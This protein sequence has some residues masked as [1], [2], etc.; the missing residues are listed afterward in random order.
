MD[1]RLE[2]E[3]WQGIDPETGFFGSAPAKAPADSTS[4]RL[5]HDGVH[6][7]MAAE[8]FEREPG[9]LR[10]KAEMRDGFGGYD[11]YVMVLFEPQIGSN[12]FYQIAVNPKGTVFDKHIEI[13]PFGTYVQDYAWNAPVS[14]G[15]KV[16]EDRWV[17][18]VSIPLEALGSQAG[19]DGR[20]GFNFRRIH[21]HIGAVSDFQVPLWY[22][23][24]RLGLLV[25]Q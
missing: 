25:F 9:R 15:T 13:C 3:V 22:A 4:L 1:G 11:D 2:E 5:C 8:C 17:A 18:E 16:Y 14:V 19:E 7:Y 21:K 12:V 20:W 23:T 10:A 6:L 24:D